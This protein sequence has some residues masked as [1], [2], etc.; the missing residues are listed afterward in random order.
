MT[1]CGDVC[2]M[3]GRE[4]EEE[5]GTASAGKSE[6]WMEGPKRDMYMVGEWV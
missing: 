3:G 1:N 4:D 2:Q 5:K 6:R